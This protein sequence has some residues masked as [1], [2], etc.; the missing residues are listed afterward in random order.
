MWFIDCVPRVHM[1]G[2]VSELSHIV[3]VSDR[4]SVMNWTYQICTLIH[5][6][7]SVINWTYQIY[8]LI[9]LYASVMNWTYQIYT[10]I[11]LYA[12]NNTRVHFSVII[13]NRTWH[14]PF[15]LSNIVLPYTILVQYYTIAVGK[16][17]VAKMANFM[18]IDIFV[19][20]ACPENSLVDS[21][22]GQYQLQN[23]VCVHT[24]L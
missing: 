2:N 11:H 17:N 21:Q 20:V 8:T 13:C 12:C 3:L 24:L 22:V 9:H 5:L 23:Q 1:S 6:Y 7:A 16:L 19:L 10:L 15:F 4:A 18:E 14:R